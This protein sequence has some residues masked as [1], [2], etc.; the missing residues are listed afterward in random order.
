MGATGVPNK[1]LIT[2]LFSDHDIDV[3]F[4]KDVGLI[5]SSMVCC[6]CGSQMS[7]CV[8]TSVKGGYWWRCLRPY[9]LPY[10]V[11]QRQL[12]MVLCFS[13][14]TWTLWRFCSSRTSSAAF[15]LT[16]SSKSIS[17]VLQPSLIGPNSVERSCRPQ[18]I[19]SVTSLITQQPIPCAAFALRYVTLG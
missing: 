17:S 14:V 13:R 16:L 12:G 7:W 18:H 10:A 3:Q 6:K 11:L 4:L 2:F 5:P 8:G 15:L 19:R 9:L 1:L